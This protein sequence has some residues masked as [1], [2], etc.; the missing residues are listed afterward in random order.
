MPGPFRLLPLTNPE[1]TFSSYRTIRSMS[2]PVSPKS[3]PMSRPSSRRGIR[4]RS[5]KAGVLSGS[6]SSYGISALA[7]CRPAGPALA[8]SGPGGKTRASSHRPAS[9]PR[10]AP[11]APLMSCYSATDARP[12][13]D[14]D[15]TSPVR[16]PG[17][18][19][20]SLGLPGVT[21]TSLPRPWTPPVS[22]TTRLNGGTGH[23]ETG[24]G[25]S[26]PAMARPFTDPADTR[27]LLKGRPGC[28]GA[29]APPKP[30]RGT[31]QRDCRPD[32]PPAR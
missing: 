28:R 32:P 27:C 13:W 11:E 7:G 24:T 10:T 25:R 9:R 21:R 12:T 18:P 29:V 6:S 5:R 22:S 20:R 2:G 1:L 30:G 17:P 3:S 14:G 23:T 16:A 15:S 26:R 8:L 19:P 31:Q 4:S